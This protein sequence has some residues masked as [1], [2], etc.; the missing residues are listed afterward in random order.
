MADVARAAGVAPMTVSNCYLAPERVH[1]ETLAKVTAAAK[2]LGYVRNRLAGG[3]A[4]GRSHVIGVTVPSLSNSNFVGLIKGL[5][6]RLSNLGY[7]LMLSVATN[8]DKE[9]AAVRTFVERRVDGIVLTGI[10]HS[11]ATIGMLKAGS[12]PVVETWSL[13]GPFIDMG[14]GFSLYDSARQMVE[15]MI[16]RG[17]KKV[18]FAGLEPRDTTR[19]KERQRGFRDA[20]EHAG[21]SGDLAAF[22]EESMGFS[23]GKVT[24]E[25]LLDQEP[26]M[27]AM[28]CVTD[29]VAAGVLF[30]CARRNWSVPDRLAVC[31]YGDYE[32]ASEI[33]PRLTTVRSPSYEMGSMAAT[34]LVD[35]ASGSA[36]EKSVRD[37]G[38][39]LVFRES[40]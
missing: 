10:E 11:H 14:V 27:D 28:F 31:G 3:L 35:R 24:L 6:D 34:L 25:R 36:Q 5:E 8:Q 29:V 32:I 26:E 22:G 4:S 39:Q 17:Y 23:A 33:S 30:E 2:K 13:N 12:I 19:Y 1:P 9:F 40:L 15:Q 18:G 7:Q 16:T 20:M 21:L 38:Y 37:V